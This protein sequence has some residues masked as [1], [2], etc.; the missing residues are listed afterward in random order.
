MARARSALR[1]TVVRRVLL[2]I[3][4]ACLAPAICGA[5]DEVLL[6]RG[7]DFVYVMPDELAA[8]MLGVAR[9]EDW[10]LVDSLTRRIDGNGD[11]EP[12]YVAIGLGTPEG[13]GAQVRY[14]LRNAPGE[15][16]KRLGSWYWAVLIGPEGRHLY[17]G[18]NP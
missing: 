5:A 14:R 15:R 17:E 6:F 18:F 7:H 4:I 10:K 16:A 2:L 8:H 13:Y 9:R 11:G 1:F 12:D 3:A